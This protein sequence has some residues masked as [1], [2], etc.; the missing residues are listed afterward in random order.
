MASPGFRRAATGAS[1][2]A[3]GARTAF[4]RA[5][6][7]ARAAA[8]ASVFVV[9]GDVIDFGG[10]A[11]PG[12][13][14]ILR[15]HA[16]ED[17]SEIF[18][19][20]QAGEGRRYAHSDAA[21]RMLRRLRV[22]T[23]ETLETLEIEARDE[24]PPSRVVRG[25][26]RTPAE[27]PARQARPK[28]RCARPTALGR[29]R[30]CRAS[31]A[32]PDE[33]DGTEADRADDRAPSSSVGSDDDEREETVVDA[34]SRQPLFERVGALGARGAYA[35]W[36]Y[37]PESTHAVAGKDAP[38]RRFAS[39]SPRFF[40]N[41]ALEFF[42]KSPWYLVPA[43][44]V[45]VALASMG[46]AWAR[47]GT[48]VRES[49]FRSRDWDGDA[50]AAPRAS[51]FL[52]R[53]A[54]AATAFAV[55]YVLWSAMEYACHRFVFHHVPRGRAGAQAHFLAHG[56]HH[57]APMD[58][59]RLT[60]PPA[61]A[62]PAI[63]LSRA[64][65]F[66]AAEIVFGALGRA[67]TFFAASPDG[68][69]RETATSEI[70]RASAFAPF[71]AAFLFSGCLMGYVAYECTHFFLHAAD[72][73]TLRTVDRWLGTRLERKK[74]AHLRHHF[75][76]HSRSFGISSERWDRAMGTEHTGRVRA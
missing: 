39:R 56:C 50:R 34:D 66:A 30:R 60:F 18:R 61:A 42:S 63:A 7:A 64:V 31:R 29:D 43:T 1:A 2:D 68:S 12:G 24:P 70:A 14:A 57:K 59:L 36:V 4:T 8:G 41:A 73:S 49:G 37:A 38:E 9:D 17:V 11:H 10:F 74:A 15:R 62:A 52:F 46:H 20:T 21:R 13:H 71:F 55:G 76:D 51:A 65:F 47:L 58:T 69:T 3:N 27:K 32:S 40:E 19:G 67:R 54:L 75:V 22:G 35:A 26:T 45:P 5:E 6:V 48:E 25:A 23:L 16:G 28:I 33:T 44:W 53:P 72:G